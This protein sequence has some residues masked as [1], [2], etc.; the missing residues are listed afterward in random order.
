MTE[1]EKKIHIQKLGRILFC[2]G[3]YNQRLSSCCVFL[4]GWMYLPSTLWLAADEANL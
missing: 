1:G 2:Y 4:F 3:K